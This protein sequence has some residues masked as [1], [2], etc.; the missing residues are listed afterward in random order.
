MSAPDG[1]LLRRAAAGQGPVARSVAPV[2]SPGKVRQVAVITVVALV[3]FFAMRAL[4]TG[5]A[6][7]HMD[8][9][10]EGKGANSIEFCDPANPQFI[11]VVAA[12]SPVSMA[13][14]LGEPPV[15]G[16]AWSGMVRLQTSSGRPVGPEDLSVAHTRKLHLLIVDPTLDDYQ[17]VHP[18]PTKTAG[19]W[20]FTFSPRRGGNYRFFAD[21]TPTA[22]GRGLYASADLAVVLGEATPPVAPRARR[23]E[24]DV[25]GYT[26]GLTTA[27]SPAQAGRPLD[28]KF[29]VR[30]TGGGPVALAPVMG[31]YAHL[32]AF[33]GARSGFAHLH[34]VESDERKTLDAINPELN[35]KLLIPRA[36]AYV[37]W[38]QVKLGG[39]DRF[40]PFPLEVLD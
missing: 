13:I 8:F 30:Q 16:R 18:E 37:I 23:A 26:F 17:H 40:V 19:E 28:L 38:A 24:V 2:F 1:G 14:A 33:D 31:A 7:S 5:T 3:I 32:V 10:V 21:F 29:K 9:R 25:A 39:V 4:P 12:R 27:R 20:A 6:L 36:G 35:F 22:T 15:A 11:P 34:P